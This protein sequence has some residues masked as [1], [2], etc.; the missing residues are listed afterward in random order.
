MTKTQLIKYIDKEL[1]TISRLTRQI[2]QSSRRANPR[3]KTARIHCR[4]V[5]GHETYTLE[6]G[7]GE[8]Y[9]SK[10]DLGF[11]KSV[12]NFDYNDRLCHILHDDERILN[13]LKAL[14][15]K[16]N[17]KRKF[18]LY[19][20][21]GPARKV[22]VNPSCI[23]TRQRAEEWAQAEYA[24]SAFR[25]EDLIHHTDKG[26]MV[27]SKN[28]Q[29]VANYFFK[30]HVPYRYECRMEL[31]GGRIIRHADF[32]VMNPFSGEIF[33]IEVAG[34]LDDKNYSDNFCTRINEYAQNGLHIGINLFVIMCTEDVPIDPAVLDGLIDN[35]LLAERISEQNNDLT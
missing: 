30:R 28:E 25:P 10:D 9:V 8:R 31:K 24:R 17:P 18:A 5:A 29:Y 1:Q 23:T 16:Y 6:E 15:L 7:A 35:V 26:D 20:A 19:N 21:M 14:L 11:A 34:K 32:T 2:E 12:A 3:V 33:I 13:A 4:M 22:L 27:R